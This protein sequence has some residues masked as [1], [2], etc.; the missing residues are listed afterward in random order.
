MKATVLLAALLAASL[1][2]K[3]KATDPNPYRAYTMQLRQT[4]AN[5][6]ATHAAIAEAQAMNEAKAEEVKEAVIEA[7]EIAEKVQLLERVCEVYEVPVPASLE[8]F[9]QIRLEDSMR[10]ANMQQLNKI[11]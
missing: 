8:D 9:E 3:D 1:P 11:K 2:V 5:I 10:V 4:E 7:Q 6:A